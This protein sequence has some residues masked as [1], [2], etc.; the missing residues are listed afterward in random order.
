MVALI[1]HHDIGWLSPSP[2]WRQTGD[3]SE[4]SARRRFV[5]PAILRFA[6]DAFMDEL[7]ALLAYRPERLGEWV[8]RAETWQRPMQ[9]PPS[10][11]Q[12][13][14]A[15]P[16]SALSV[17]LT[18]ERARAGDASPGDTVPAAVGDEPLKL[19][20]PIHQRFY[21]LTASLVCRTPGLPER[22]V[23][24]GNQERVGFVVRRILPPSDAAGPAA[25]PAEW[26]EY[27]Y[28]P[29]PGGGRWQPVRSDAD[30]SARRLLPGEERLALFP[31]GFEEADG[32]RR[33]L[34]GGLVP[35]GRREAYLGAGMDATAEAA[36]AAADDAFPDAPA[37]PRLLLLQLQVTGPWMELV[38]QSLDARERLDRRTE[39]RSAIEGE[40]DDGDFQD[41]T[42]TASRDQIQTISWYALL[43][44]A[45]YLE[46]YLEAVWEV[47]AG[48]RAEA[49]LGTEQASLLD[50]L[51]RIVLDG[52]LRIQL[53]QSPYT[54]ADVPATLRQALERFAGSSGAAVADGLE[55]VEGSFQRGSAAGEAGWPGF[56]FPLADARGRGPFP[57][58]FDGDNL[59]NGDIGSA[60]ARSALLERTRG[61]LGE[62]EARIE[63]ALPDVAAT[64]APE[65][66]PPL[67]KGARP[68][69]G[70]FALRCVYERPNCGPRASEVVSEP[71]EAFRM[72]SFFDP[73]APGRPIRIP[74]PLDVSPAGL[75]KFNKNATIM[76]SDMLCGRLRRI[77]KFSLG[78]LVLSVLPWPFHKDLPDPTAGAACNTSGG[79]PFGMF[80]SLSIPIV[81]L[82]ALILLIIM[83]SLFD[84]FFRWLPY[85]FLC[86]PIPGLRG[87]RS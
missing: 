73:D 46:Q 60:T 47:I 6:H 25:D 44:L 22:A 63:A 71:T 59:A 36:S 57:F 17:R 16:V 65:I 52:A 26:D 84:L 7:L 8:A 80:C 66:T 33:R 85:L 29:G 78:D 75:R 45:R 21:L 19:Y 10:A 67:A 38:Q 39:G 15:E 56:L 11:A 81:T 41:Q 62:L 82:C 64:G 24:A 5:R 70:W 18:R 77:R 42:L 34:F 86:L 12:L 14:L 54:L 40:F 61:A 13:Q 2:T 4:H 83:V 35:V 1:P 48:Q 37:D 20:Q 51:G 68:R 76:I 28:I 74:M 58:R 50:L 87:K 32:R 79:T 72:A 27:A 30:D 55:A 23:D 53:A 31:V 43:D 9:S 3:L 69:D 49:T